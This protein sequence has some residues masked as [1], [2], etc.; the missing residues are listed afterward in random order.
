[1]PRH[2]ACPVCHRHVRA[3]APRCPFCAAAPPPRDL[4][5]GATAPAAGRAHRSA[6][7]ALA[8]TLALAG[9]CDTS[10]SAVYGGP[11][12][13]APVQSTTTTPSTS[14]SAST[15]AS[16]GASVVPSDAAVDLSLL[17][18]AASGG[19][20]DLGGLKIPGAVYG[21][22]PTDKG[23][24][25]KVPAGDVAV[26]PM[27]GAYADAEAT[28][29]RNRWRL[30][31]CYTKE[32]AVDPGASGN[33]TVELTIDT[34]GNVSSVNVAKSTAPSALGACVKAGLANLK[35]TPPAAKTKVSVP[36]SFKVAP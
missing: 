20:L 36:I 14:A 9:G 11:P 24:L 34:D 29:A 8:S 13:R 5:P 33:V 1:M 27:T 3:A 19:P 12:T 10:P 30:K 6:F 26:G 16:T 35:F 17:G 23:A 18:D 15:P 31:A 7:F 21:G 28:F 4:G 32:L 22:P 25:L 2:I